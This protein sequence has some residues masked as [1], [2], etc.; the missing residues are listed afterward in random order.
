M[1]A[2]A[3]TIL[4]VFG[5]CLPNVARGQYGLD[6]VPNSTFYHHHDWRHYGTDPVP[7]T[8][9]HTDGLATT[10]GVDR[11]PGL[12]RERLDLHPHH[13]L[14]HETIQHLTAAVEYTP[15]QRKAKPAPKSAPAV[16]ATESRARPQQIAPSR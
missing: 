13:E 3:F 10:F 4:L 16:K 9:K 1:K 5:V 12:V 15:P 14:I 8:M 11:V 6:E 7:N 2:V